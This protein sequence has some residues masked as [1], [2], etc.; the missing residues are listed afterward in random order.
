MTDLEEWPLLSLV[1]GGN[2]IRL[3]DPSGASLPPLDR[4]LTKGNITA[5]PSYLDL[6]GVIEVTDKARLDRFERGPLS[7]LHQ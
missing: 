2:R 6:L 5:G 1:R 7:Y 4:I 3:I